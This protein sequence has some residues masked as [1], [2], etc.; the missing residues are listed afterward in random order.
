MMSID[1]KAI[2]DKLERNTTDKLNLSYCNIGNEEVKLLA[3]A[4]AINTSVKKCYL[5]W[6]NMSDEEAEAIATAL[7]TNKTITE[8]HLS[9]NKIGK[10]GAKGIAKALKTNTTLTHLHLF[11]N[12]IGDEGTEEIA[13]GLTRNTSITHLDLSANY[14]G[15]IGTIALAR[16]LATNTISLTMLDLRGNNI[17]AEGVKAL[18]GA[19]LT[20]TTLA[21]LILSYTEIGDAGLKAL[22]AVLASN[23]SLSILYLNGMK[24]SEEII[25]AFATALT[26]NTTLTRLSFNNTNISVELKNKIETLLKRNESY[27]TLIEKT[28]EGFENAQQ[29]ES[30]EALQALLE[31]L[32]QAQHALDA[33]NYAKNG[34]GYKKINIIIYVLEAQ[35]ALYHNAENVAVEKLT[36]VNKNEPYFD[37]A[38]DGLLSIAQH[39]LYVLYTPNETI[40]QRNERFNT[41]LKTLSHID[42][43]N[44][45]KASLIRIIE[46]SKLLRQRLKADLVRP[47]TSEEMAKIRTKGT[48]EC[49]ALYCNHW[50]RPSNTDA[51][52]RSKTLF[53]SRSQKV[54]SMQ[55]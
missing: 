9:R 19:L 42:D 13:I 8:L 52:H 27:Q 17:G 50:Q 28:I 18:A 55:N 47:R 49:P 30:L 32:R 37:I 3:T 38:Q 6:S 39:Q 44:S 25:E 45:F 11:K 48:Q 41:V 1:L 10:E 46:G 31:P 51:R 16:G 40:E 7:S 53:S 22:A 54:S 20:N 43:N 4:L 34:L 21:E 36:S 26:T 12:N 2:I 14:I 29:P 15:A 35:I 33:A 5:F 24:M 23:T